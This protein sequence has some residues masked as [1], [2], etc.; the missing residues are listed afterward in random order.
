MYIMRAIG[1]FGLMVTFGIL[2]E[3]F[4]TFTKSLEPLVREIA[5]VADF[6]EVSAYP[7]V[8]TNRR[9]RLHENGVVSYAYAV[10]QGWDIKIV[11]DKVQS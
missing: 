2:W 10:E 6:Q 5:Y 4:P 8:D 11:V 3:D 1:A 9:L 7:G